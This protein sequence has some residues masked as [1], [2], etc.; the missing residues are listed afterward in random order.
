[1]LL[2]KAACHTFGIYD[3]SG[4]PD[5][6]DGGGVGDTVDLCYVLRMRLYTTSQKMFF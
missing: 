1:M 6:V 2:L 4:K 5:N 3:Y